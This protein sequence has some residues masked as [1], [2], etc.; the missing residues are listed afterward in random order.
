M[1]NYVVRVRR[2]MSEHEIYVEARSATRALREAFESYEL[3]CYGEAGD[4]PTFD[5]FDRL[6]ES[7]EQVESA[8]GL[9]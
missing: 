8:G 7:M 3:E 6:V 5:E 4:R 9:G 2:G 1:K